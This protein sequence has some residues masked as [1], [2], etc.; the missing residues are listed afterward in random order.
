[1]SSCSFAADRAARNLLGAAVVVSASLSATTV[2]GGSPSRVVVAWTDQSNQGHLRSF[3]A[4]APWEFDTPELNV[5]AGAT[6]R[7]AGGLLYVVSRTDATVAVVDPADWTVLQTQSVGSGREPV[8]IAIVAPDLAYVSCADETHLLRF[9]PI[10]G[11]TTPIVD[12]SGFAD[13]D[14]VPDLGMM[15]VHE[16][17]LFLQIQRRDSTNFGFVPPGMIAVVDLATEQLIDVDPLAPGVQAIELQGTAP[18]F[19]M[20]IVESTRRLFVSASG[21]FFDAGGIEMIDL[22]TFASLGL[23]VR[24]E[25]DMVGADLG[26]FVLVTPDRGYLTFSTDL[27]LSSHMVEFTVTG[28]VVPSGA[29]FETVGYF[30]PT[31]PHDPPSGTIYFPDGGSF[32]SAVHALSGADGSHL[33]TITLGASMLP[34][35][36]LVIPPAGSGP[37]VPAVSTWGMLILALLI[38]VA[39]GLIQ[40]RPAR[41]RESLAR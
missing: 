10:T 39:A 35:D 26:A 13:P 24:E 22:D 8:D 19:K 41:A 20:Q 16:N 38:V 30:V 23:V 17:R 33:A 37:A 34:T 3:P 15:T 7:Y 11:E 36:V 25:D 27:A 18:K 1:M 28:G 40:H 32:P 14:G 12:L 5:G 29:L 2:A 4:A 6:L 31:L 21:E 9:N